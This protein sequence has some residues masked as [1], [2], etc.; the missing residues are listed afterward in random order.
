MSDAE[1]SGEIPVT[2]KLKLFFSVD[3]VNSTEFKSKGSTVEHSHADHWERTFLTFYRRSVIDIS[4]YWKQ[5]IQEM[6]A[7]A[8]GSL[9][10][11][12]GDA[13]R[14]WKGVGDE[15]LF[16]KTV[17]SPLDAVAGV[18]ALLRLVE[19]HREQFRSKTPTQSLDVKAT[20]WLAGFPINNAEVVFDESP[21]VPSQPG[22]DEITE[23]FRLLARIEKPDA[24]A[25][26]KLDFLGTSID[27]GFRLRQHASP[28]K[29]IVSADLVWLLCQARSACTEHQI[30][31]CRSLELPSIGFDGSVF[32]KGILGELSSYPLFW[33]ASAPPTEGE[34]LEEKLVKRAGLES[35]ILRAYCSRF[36]DG[37][38]ALLMTP[39]IPDCPDKSVATIHPSHQDKLDRLRNHVNGSSAQIDSVRERHP[40]AGVD[41]LPA[42]TTRFADDVA[43]D[44]KRIDDFVK[45][46]VGDNVHNVKGLDD[47]PGHVA[48]LTAKLIADASVKDITPARL[49]EAIG[50]LDDFLTNEYEQNH[51]PTAGLIKD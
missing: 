40:D 3:I 12:F 47:L 17:K 23:N 19:N 6:E 37:S 9:H 43:R 7:V 11:A 50:D 4:I 28:R 48:Q 29:A 21:A 45:D 13:P 34:V 5:V 44:V 51:D 41:T 38:H 16:E 30:G 35:P 49:L 42:A 22:A 27:L 10:F 14:F 20:A 39:Y 33:I 24:P 36:L 31:R 18:R 46:W 1:A 26:Y 25:N 15:V 32:L 8:D 2:S